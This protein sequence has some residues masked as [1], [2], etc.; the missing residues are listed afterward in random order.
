MERLACVDLPEFPLQLL[1][2]KHPEWK[3]LPSAVV[4]HDKPQGEIQL[5]SPE[6]RAAGVLP[7]MRYAQGLSLAVGLRAAEVPAGEVEAAIQVLANLLRRFSPDVEAS[8]EEPGVFWLNAA[9]L[10]SI[11]QS[12]DHWAETIHSTLAAGGWRASV[13]VGFRRFA[14]YVIA[15]GHEDILVLP[16]ANAEE[17]AFYEVPLSAMALH[18]PLRDTLLKLGILTMG[19]FVR[20]PPAAVRRRFGSEAACF[21]ALARGETFDPFA[22]EFPA[23]IAACTIMPE[24]PESNSVC[25]LSAIQEHLEP[26]LA[27]LA[28]RNE[29]LRELEVSF[30]LERH[31]ERTD[32][33]RPAEKTLDESLIMDLLRLKLEGFPLPAPA[34]EITL[35]AHGTPAAQHQIRLFLKAPKRDMA[36]ANRALARIRSELGEH[37][38]VRARLQEGHLPETRFTWEQLTCLPKAN[39][40]PVRTAAM[41]RRL[42]SRPAF[43]ASRPRQESRPALDRIFGAVNHS[44]GPYVISGQWWHS[45]DG[46]AIHRC[47]YFLETAGGSTLW[48]YYDSRL[49]QWFLH[50]QVE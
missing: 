2:A 15:K 11:F 23:E 19:E 27:K 28:A 32:F 39:P 17:A 50:G 16:D 45:S 37:T 8:K 41:V 14:V 49:K 38:V 36:A 34:K 22:P 20:L 18:P 4:A 42:Y 30:L 7:G 24:N 31:G 12:F 10:L 25:I 26:L 6:A 33:I 43:M 40:A 21:H 35:I 13:A 3:K 44:W 48:V 29:A 47:Y 9:G 46:H 5:A 1:L